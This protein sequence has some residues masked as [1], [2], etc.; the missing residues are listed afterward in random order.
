MAV[1]TQWVAVGHAAGKRAAMHKGV[2]SAGAEKFWL[3]NRKVEF[4]DP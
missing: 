2:H 3:K 1:D 4:I